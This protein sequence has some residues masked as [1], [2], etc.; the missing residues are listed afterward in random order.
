MFKRYATVKLSTNVKKILDE[1]TPPRKSHSQ[2]VGELTKNARLLREQVSIAREV[3]SHEEAARIAMKKASSIDGFLLDITNRTLI[4]VA[5][6]D[7]SSTYGV[8]RK[9]AKKGEVFEFDHSKKRSSFDREARLYL[10]LGSPNKGVI[11]V[12]KGK[13]FH[14]TVWTVSYMGLIP[15]KIRVV[16]SSKKKTKSEYKSPS[17]E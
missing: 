11:E 3:K 14:S 17:D 8:S 7:H 10:I 9:G 4:H 16:Q 15:F 12:I 6:Y 1:L 13:E 5:T 2:V